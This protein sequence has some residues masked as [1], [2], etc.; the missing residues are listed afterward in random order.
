MLMSHGSE[1]DMTRMRH[2]RLLVKH[3]SASMQRDPHAHMGTKHAVGYSRMPACI[4][5]MQ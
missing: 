5:A 3:M 1:C 2:V 4:A